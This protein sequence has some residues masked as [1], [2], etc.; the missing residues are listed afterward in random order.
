M[1]ELNNMP[2]GKYNYFDG[3]HTLLFELGCCD[4]CG[5]KV[6][7]PNVMKAVAPSKFILTGMGFDKEWPLPS[8]PEELSCDEDGMD[9][10]INCPD[11]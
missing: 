1:P 8:I 10:C 4:T 6:T 3:C 11:E 2:E 9:L 7:L 5:S